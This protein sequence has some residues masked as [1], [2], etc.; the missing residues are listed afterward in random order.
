MIRQFFVSLNDK[1]GLGDLL[2]QI[3]ASDVVIITLAALVFVCMIVG[4]FPIISKLSFIAPYASVAA[5]LVY[6]FLSAQAFLVGYRFADGRVEAKVLREAISVRDGVITGQ[7]ESLDMVF[8]AAETAVKQRD[9][10][11]QRAQE[12]QDQID[13]YEKR[14]KGRPNAACLLT[15]DDFADG[16]QDHRKR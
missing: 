9:E 13:E 3:A 7:R 2:W 15:P 1:L 14:L 6:V 10:A 16:V 11:A 12:A 4:H 8:D 5:A